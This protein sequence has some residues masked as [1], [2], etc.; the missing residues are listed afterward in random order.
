MQNLVMQVQ[1]VPFGTRSALTLEVNQAAR[2][3]SL[4]ALKLKLV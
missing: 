3:G 1:E 2:N 4:L